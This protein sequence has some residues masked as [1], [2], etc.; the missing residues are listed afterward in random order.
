VL[1]FAAGYLFRGGY[2]PTAAATPM[3][4]SILAAL[5]IGMFYLTG[6]LKYA[7]LFGILFLVPFIDMT[8]MG[9]AVFIVILL[10]HFANRNMV[11]K[12][13][14]AGIGLLL[15]TVV[16]NSD[17]FREKT[18]NDSGGTVSLSDISGNLNYYENKNIRNT[19]RDT[20]YKLLEP[21]IEARPVFGN[22]PRADGLVLSSVYY[23]E[24]QGE[25]HN[26][27]LSVTY[28]YG[29]TGLALLLF[30]FGSTFF[31]LFSALRKTECL[32]RRLI[33]TSTMTLMVGFLMFMYSDNT[34]KY[35]IF[36]PNL[37]FALAGI[38]FAPYRSKS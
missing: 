3:L 34:L 19:G 10:V 22:G 31:A 14:M 25:S 29:Y 18:V 38:V 1:L 17:K 9:V 23:G 28:N 6:K 36:F 5:L 24:K 13:V 30:G 2:T 11:S 27:Y 20:W 4:L 37:F 15:V 26:D 12:A 21:G 16:L 8:R 32:Y 35:T 33:V 7:T